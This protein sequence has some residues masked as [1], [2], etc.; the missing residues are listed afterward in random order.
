MNVFGFWTRP[1][2]SGVSLP[3][4]RNALLELFYA[5]ASSISYGENSEVTVVNGVPLTD[6][7][8]LV[9][10]FLKNAVLSVQGKSGKVVAIKLAGNSKDAKSKRAGNLQSYTSR[11]EGYISLALLCL[12]SIASPRWWRKWY[13]S[14]ENVLQEMY[15]RGEIDDDLVVSN[16]IK[17]F[18][19]VL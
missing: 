5:P 11:Y 15:K 9:K 14:K 6:W 18:I 17:C 10:D 8:A 12:V 2:E 16:F 1:K 4:T 19:T 3:S 13:K 7:P